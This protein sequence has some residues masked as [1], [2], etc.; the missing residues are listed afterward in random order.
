MNNLFDI[1]DKVIV[2]T[3]ATGVLAGGVARYLLEQGAQVVFLGRHQDKVAALLEEM[4]NVPGKYS[5]YVCDVLDQTALDTVYQQIMQQFNRVDV[6]INGAGGNMPG[7]TIS[8][9][10]DIAN[11][12]IEDYSKVLDLNLKGTL[13]PIMTFVKA[14]VQQGKGCV[15]NFSSM[16][17]T[18]ALTRVLGYSNA[19]AGIDNLTRWMAMELA[20]KY[21]DGIR[22]N[23]VAPGF[24]ISH[25]NRALLTND[26]GSYTERGNQ[27]IN[28]TPFRRFGEPQEVFGAIHYLI[29]DAAS[30]VTGAIVPIDGGFSSFTGV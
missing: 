1:S 16:S 7:A 12:K 3:G 19:K 10:E 29:S 21:G 26:D 4:K 28:K 2:V 30:F 14:F 6:L 17:S 13:L 25:Q 23:A 22:V 9:E 20:L 24:F 15:V 27:V 5:G 18:Q 8:P 11:L